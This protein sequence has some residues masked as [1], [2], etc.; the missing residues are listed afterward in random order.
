MV[1]F[2]ACQGNQSD[3]A[4]VKESLEPKKVNISYNSADK[5]PFNVEIMNKDGHSISSAERLENKP[6]VMLFWLTTCGPCKREI[7]ALKSA[8]PQWQKEYD[9]DIVLISRDFEKNWER[10]WT[11]KDEMSWNF[12]TYIDKN[13]K[14]GELLPGTN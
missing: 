7:N 14:F 3:S 12:D 11:L 8:V 2:V 4:D 1:F 9:F 10:V 13:R 5:Y 6:T